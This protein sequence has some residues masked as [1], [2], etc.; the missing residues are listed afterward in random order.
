MDLILLRCI[1]ATERFESV[2]INCKEAGKNVRAIL[3]TNPHIPS[4]K[5]WSPK[6]LIEVMEWAA[7]KSLE[8]VDSLGLVGC[9]TKE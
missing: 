6:E 1:F 2:Y 3:L 8:V 7:T 4:G 9:I 5:A